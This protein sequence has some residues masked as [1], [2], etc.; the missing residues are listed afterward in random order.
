MMISLVSKKG[1]KHLTA[2]LYFKNKKHSQK[3]DGHFFNTV[4]FSSQ[5]QNYN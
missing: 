3:R 5:S 2:S 4:Y 1:I